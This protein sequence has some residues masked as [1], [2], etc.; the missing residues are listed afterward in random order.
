MKSIFSTIF[1]VCWLPLLTAAPAPPVTAIAYHPGGKFLAAGTYREVA[2]VNPQNGDVVSKLT[3][4]T[5]RVT[6]LAFTKSGDHFAVASGEPGKM[7]EIRLYE[8]N[9]G[10]AKQVAVLSA[11]HKDVI[12]ALAFSPDGML[13]A[14]AGYDRIIKLWN[15][16]TH[17]LVKMLQ[18]H[19]DTIYGL[20]FH[21]AGKLLAS[22]AADRAVKI[23]DIATGKRLYTLSD[24]TD[25]VYTVAWSPDGKHLA[26]GGIDKSI[27]VWEANAEG[28]KLA[29]SVF[30]HTKPITR[31]GYSG[32]GKALFSISEGNT[33]K[34]WDAA[35]MKETFVFPPQSETMLSLALRP[36]QKQI[37]VGRFDGALILLNAEDGKPM[38]APLPAKPK[39]PQ[40]QKLIPNT[41]LRGT[42]IRIAI[43]GQHLDEVSQIESDVVG[44][45]AKL[46]NEGR[47]STRLQ[48][49]LVIPTTIP[50]GNVS[51]SLKS[52]AGSSAKLPFTVDRYPAIAETGAQDS[53]RIGM[54]VNAPATLVGTIGKAGDADYFRFEVKAN[55][56]IAVQALTAAIGSKLEPILE[57]T[58]DKGTVLL[59]SASGLLGYRCPLTGTLS[60]GIRDR[61]FRGGA[62][63]KYRISLG[64]FPMITGV[65]PLSI[66]RGIVTPVDLIG[67]NLGDKHHVRM[68]APADAAPKSK[69]A[70]PLPEF[71]EKVIGDAKVVV[72]EFPE[73]P[74]VRDEASIPVPGTATGVIHEPGTR[75]VV[76]FSATKGNRVIVEVEARRLG[77]PLDSF[78]E[79]LDYHNRPVMR[80][81]LRCVA[82]TFMAF[83]DHDSATPGIR[84]ETWNELAIDDYIYVNGELMRINE[85]PKNP[86]DDCQFYQVSGQ[87]VGFLATT[88]LHHAM[89][90]VMYKVEIH[91]PGSTFPPNGM[92]VF[93]V[94]YRND[95]GGPGFGKDSFLFFDPPADGAYRVRIGDA[96]GQG[97][98]H[99]AYRMSVRPPRPDYSVSFNPTSPG[100]RKGG[101][102]PINVNATR[103]DGFNGPIHVKLNNLPPGFDA[104]ASFI[105]PGQTSTTFALFAT[106]TASLPQK[107]APVR[108]TATANINGQDRIHEVVGGAPQIIEPGDIVTTTSVPEIVL[109]PG[110]ETKFLA[111]V[112]RRNGFAGRIPL[113]VRGLPHGVRVLN[114]GLNGIL[115]TER[116]T[117]R[118]ITVYAEPWVKP[119]ERPF[120][121]LAKREGKNTEH[122]AKS[123][124]L[125]INP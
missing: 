106:A 10:N 37:A 3:G 101:S 23:W 4:F 66:A 49:D 58:D 69:I 79:I 29:H 41:G 19:S 63:F 21:A 95:D 87:R 114:I 78:I 9:A 72:G 17:Q 26:A 118:E 112:E 113:E 62:D 74:V 71:S 44:A 81:T 16:S 121:V 91:P 107:T 40:L 45:Q 102:I 67:V 43:E 13:L 75:Q 15:T 96:R 18:D 22:A 42:T 117:Q 32:D 77:S 65:T 1:C 50:V 122:G 2:I 110:Q 12:Y 53:P 123:L 34:R 64:D 93:N 82:R 94:A 73:R 125:R 103:I 54:K 20:S 5:D 11:A 31:I 86:D 55:Q 120:I 48:A 68:S 108:L 89:G 119:M 39:P 35:T 99:F 52:P 14:S 36:D 83:R 124:L 116:D 57:L 105:E 85:L 100:V 24:P 30:A 88:P 59:E 115:I 70:V 90:S 28:A 76:Q 56:E 98:P 109:R 6:A 60:L 84:L 47:T 111:S 38:A 8:W 61:E 46:L 104:P 7:G 97:G 33:I 25:W 27:R 92:P 51:L 80:A